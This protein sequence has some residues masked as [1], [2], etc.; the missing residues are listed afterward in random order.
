MDVK[1]HSNPLAFIRHHH[2]NS[3][4]INDSC[5]IHKSA[6][7]QPRLRGATESMELSK[8]QAVAV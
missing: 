4:T 2:C 5:M 8:A 6:R 3:S 7:L 1:L